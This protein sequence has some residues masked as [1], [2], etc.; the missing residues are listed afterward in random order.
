MGRLPTMD[1]GVERDLGL[2]ASA[3]S[4]R[5]VMCDRSDWNFLWLVR[6]VRF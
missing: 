2:F 4:P 1:V 3:D 6:W 5:D